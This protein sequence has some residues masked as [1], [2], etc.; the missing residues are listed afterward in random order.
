MSFLG[1]VVTII[2]LAVQND[3]LVG[4]GLGTSAATICF[5]W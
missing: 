1:L 4:Y 5:Y 3:Y 2:G